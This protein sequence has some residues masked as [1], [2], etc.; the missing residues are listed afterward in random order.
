M[1][2]LEII[3]QAVAL[4]AELHACISGGKDSQAMVK[5]MVGNGLRPTT[6]VHCDLGFVEWPESIEQCE[7]LSAWEY[8]PLHVVRRKDGTG[9]LDH[10]KNRMKK[11]QGKGIP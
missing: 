10:W 3:R 1:N 4:G 9:L 2:Q 6:L 7:K 5:Y 11:V 8:I